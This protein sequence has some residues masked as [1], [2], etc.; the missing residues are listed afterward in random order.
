MSARMLEEP[1]KKMMKG[2]VRV[3]LAGALLLLV[4]P[5]PA[6]AVGEQAGR[7]RGVVTEAGTGVPV[8]AAKVEIRSSSQIG[9]PR[10]THTGDD[11]KFDFLNVTPGR[12]EITVTVEGIRP[13]RRRA[14][15]ALAQT[16][17]LDIPFSA[18]MAAVET[19][20]IQEERKRLD[21][22][23]VSTGVVLT[24]ERESKLATGR[25][26]Q[27]I[28]QQ[29]PGVVGGGNPVMAG[30][31]FRHNR[32]LVD[33]LD[34]TDP[35]TNTF[36]ANFNFDVIAQEEAITVPV[37]AQYNS[38]G[39]VINLITKT[40]SDRWEVDSSFYL[41]HQAL[42]GGGRYGSKL[43]ESKLLDQSDPRPPKAD[44]AYNLNVGGPLVKQKLWIYIS[45]QY[46]YRL[47]STVPGPPLNEQHPASD[48]HD[49]YPRLKLTW[50]ISPRQRLTLSFNADPAFIYNTRN[51]N[52]NPNTYAPESEYTQKQLGEFGT[53]SWD[54]FLTEKLLLS[55]QAGLI[56]QRLIITPSN[57]DLV[58]ST[59]FDQATS[60]TYNAAGFAR[61]Q[62]DQRWRFQLDPTITWSR[63]GWLGSHT[64]KAG[65]QFQ[66]LHHYQASSTPGNSL[67]T[68]DTSQDPSLSRDPASRS[69]PTPCNPLHPYP[70]AGSMATPCYQSTFYE[71]NRALGRGGYGVGTFIQD[72]W[73]PTRWL[74]VLGGLRIDYGRYTNSLGE[75]V[76]NLLGFGPR[77][78][79][80]VDLSRD[81][82]TLFK[83]AYG[84]ANEVNTLLS[85]GQA[86]LG[87]FKSTYQFNPATGRF[88]Q[89]FSSGGGTTGYDL[90][91][92]CQDGP[93]KGKATLACGN[94]ALNL[95]PPQTDSVIVSLERALGA[96]VVGGI[97]YTYRKFS[98]LW[99]DIE[100]NQ[101]STLDGRDVAYYVD[102]RYGNISAYRPAPD[103]W[104]RY[105]GVDFSITGQ[106]SPNWFFF[107]AYTLAFLD[108]SLS[109][110]FGPLYDQPN[111]NFLFHGYLPDDHRH[112]VKAQAYYTWGGL[113][114]GANLV[115]LTGAPA[116]RLFRT[117]FGFVDYGRNGWNGVDP[118]SDPNDIR[119]WTEL[120]SPDIMNIDLRA[121]YDFHQLIRQH[122][123][124]IADIFNAFDLA[125]PAAAGATNQAGFENRNTANYGNVT[126]RQLPLAVQF[127]LRYQWG[128]DIR[129]NAA[130]TKPQ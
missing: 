101:R 68:D 61:N 74:T 41:Q 6:F 95:H 102:P 81:G 125:T 18:E 97:Q 21:Q 67:Y 32:Y 89:F 56:F 31:T 84:R 99:D 88:D 118:G 123:T 63:D 86:D 20:V 127:G 69:L 36:S 22:D 92:I 122:I 77:V 8:P 50:A 54:A 72:L 82:R 106:P 104:R 76:Q 111:R 30:G 94:A 71:P 34:I 46:R 26:Y 100:L 107:V 85:A 29:A 10:S 4:A 116:T 93:D 66:Y 14:S 115:F 5:R 108:G 87:G 109:D 19:T 78:A 12:Y 130:P 39:G 52:P 51:L 83:F 121:Q 98:Y 110:Q 124:L 11:G 59:H 44:Y 129:A 7:L 105:N 27:D 13:V 57:D 42:T 53:L 3:L 55:V 35:V 114:V 103:S 128:G 25:R 91:G 58:N 64:F 120:R 112:Q 49:I 16:V 2:T 17:D 90:R 48:R 70:M 43:Y 113:T 126:G 60:I 24:S 15:V 119:K 73:K 62:D 45:T 79:V 96:S 23:R 65:V 40:G 28:A 38:M 117:A 9:G 47:V 75:V 1:R 80:N 37:D 33:G